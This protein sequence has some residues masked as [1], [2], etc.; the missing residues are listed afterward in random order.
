MCST[1]MQSRAVRGLPFPPGLVQVQMRIGEVNGLPGVQIFQSGVRAPGG[2]ALQMRV[3]NIAWPPIQV[4][5]AARKFRDM[6]T[7]A[8]ADL[9]HVAAL[10]RKETGDRQPDRFVIAVKCRSVQP[11]VACRWLTIFAVLDDEFNHAAAENHRGSAIRHDRWP[12][13]KAVCRSWPAEDCIT[14]FVVFTDAI[15]QNQAFRR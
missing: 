5:R 13:S 7:G 15:R 11:A 14:A 8:A 2:N 4:R 6:L 1:F 12:G 10:R 3:V 9:Q